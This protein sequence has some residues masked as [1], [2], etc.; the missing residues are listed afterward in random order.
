MRY[1][2]LT[3]IHANLEALDA[4]LAD[5]QRA[6]ASTRRSCS[7]TSSATAAIPMPSSSGSRRSSRRRS[8]AAT[9]TR[10][11]AASSRPKGSTPWRRAP[12]SGRSTSLT[13]DHR[14]WLARAAG[15]ADRRRRGRRDLPRLAVR[16]GRLHLRR[17][18]RRPRAEGRRTVS[19]ACSATRTIPSPSSCRPTRS[20]ASG[21]RR[22][23][24]MQVQMKDGCKY[25]INPGSVGQPRDGDPRAA[26][27]IVDTSA[28]DRGA[29]PD[30]VRDRRSA[31]QGREGRAARR[32]RAAAGGRTIR[33]RVVQ[34]S[35]LVR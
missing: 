29:V 7:A 30:A 10:S 2:V 20:T 5:A 17:A 26:Y 11:R 21:R 22:R 31:D 28:A 3:D 34:T 6:R 24:Q 33:V 32:A 16:R 15:R 18:R 27:A 9:T 35:K 25:L 8:C 1:L 13:P 23:R 19:S 4:C 14:D 12:R